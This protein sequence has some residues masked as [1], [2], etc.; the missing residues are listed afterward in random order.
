MRRARKRTAG[1]C[2]S[3]NRSCSP[4]KPS[5][6]IPGGHPSSMARLIAVLRLP[7]VSNSMWRSPF[8]DLSSTGSPGASRPAS[9]N[10]SDRFQPNLRR[11]SMRRQ[12]QSR[13]RRLEPPFRV[14][15]GRTW[16]KKRGKGQELKEALKCFKESVGE[17]DHE[18]E[19]ESKRQHSA[20]D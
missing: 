19:A 20:G 16:T 11:K 18:A 4:F 10:S 5:A 7:P 3:S 12:L 6:L 14:V 1:R 8:D 13:H 9:T 15:S 17:T 2:S